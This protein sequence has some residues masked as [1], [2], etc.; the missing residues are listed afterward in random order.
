MRVVRVRV[1]LYLA[2]SSAAV[3]VI[4]LRAGVQQQLCSLRPMLVGL[5]SQR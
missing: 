5:L 2:S 1:G 3:V 4:V